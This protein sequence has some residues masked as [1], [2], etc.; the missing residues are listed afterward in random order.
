MRCTLWELGHSVLH[1]TAPLIIL[2]SIFSYLL[3]HHCLLL[4]LTPLSVTLLS[5]TSLRRLLLLSHFITRLFSHGAGAQRGAVGWTACKRHIFLSG[6]L[7]RLQTIGMYL[8]FAHTE[9][10]VDGREKGESLVCSLIGTGTELKAVPASK[11]G[12]DPGCRAQLSL[13]CQLLCSLSS[14]HCSSSSIPV[15]QEEGQVTLPK[16]KGP[17]FFRAYMNAYRLLRQEHPQLL[18]NEGPFFQNGLNNWFPF[19]TLFP[20]FP[21]KSQLFICAIKQ[22]AAFLSNRQPYTTSNKSRFHCLLNAN[23]V[24]L[25]EKK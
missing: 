5:P 20:D 10:Q 15:P 4:L 23:Q 25:S 17:F 14:G 13:V 9:R 16:C 11:A 6:N 24:I 12:S 7:M 2:F 22:R 19:S 1:Q 18:R 8:F 21:Q 3:P